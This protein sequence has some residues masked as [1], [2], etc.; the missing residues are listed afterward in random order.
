MVDVLKNL[1]NIKASI[2]NSNTNIIAVSKTFPIDKVK[3]LYEVGH[4]HFGEN[5]VQEAKMKWASVKQ[6]NPKLKLHMI[7]KL[8][9]NKAKDAVA[10]FDY[11]HSLDNEKL[12]N[13]LAKSEK[14]LNKKNKY[15]IQV[16]IGKEE[17]KSGIRVDQ[18]F[19]FYN[20]CQKILID[21]IGLMC[22][23]PIDKNPKEY[24]TEL[25]K[26]NKSLKL[27]EISMGM[28][29]DYLKAVDCGSTFV[30]IG[31]AIFGNR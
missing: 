7:G 12:A 1:K 25:V 13:A 30:R 17:Q 2:S 20:F 6:L 16:N 24:F 23:P 15:F 22:I 3:P 14:L 26:L 8:Q 9:S 29:S 31:S 5:K 4:L 21:V 11:I 28:S 10:L 19:G 27:K 18:I